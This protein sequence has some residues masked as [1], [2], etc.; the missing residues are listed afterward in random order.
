MDIKDL[1]DAVWYAGAAVL[2]IVIFLLLFYSQIADVISSLAKRGIKTSHFSIDGERANAA[3][4]ISKDDSKSPEKIDITQFHLPKIVDR[5]AE[6]FRELLNKCD[7]KDSEEREKWL[8]REAADIFYQRE[9]ERA[10]MWMYG[11]QMLLLRKLNETQEIGID[12][13]KISE[14]FEQLKASTGDFYNTDSAK[15]W[16]GHLVNLGFAMYSDN[17]MLITEIGKSFIQYVVGRGYSLDGLFQ[18]QRV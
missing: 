14:Q 15:R 1:P 4:Q 17:R 18:W 13:T 12:V 9:F 6:E 2:V 3:V 10:Y 7:F 11:S 16:S 5:K 8:F